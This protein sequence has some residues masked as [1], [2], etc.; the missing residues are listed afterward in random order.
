MFTLRQLDNLGCEITFSHEVNE[1]F[2]RDII[3]VLLSLKRF[4]SLLIGE[5]KGPSLIKLVEYVL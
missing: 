4:T 5:M 2:L 1:E 3:E